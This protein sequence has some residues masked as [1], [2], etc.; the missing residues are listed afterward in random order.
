MRRN[1]LTSLIPWLFCLASCGLVL[2]QINVE[3]SFEPPTITQANNST[4]KVVINGSQQS[5]SGA[6]P[7]VDGLRFSPQPRTLKSASFINGVPSIRFELS[8]TVSPE[9][10]GSF[11]VPPWSVKVGNQSY[12][13]P[14]AKLEVLPP[15][16]QDKIKQAQKRQQQSDLRQAAFLEFSC[17]RSFLFEGETVQASVSLFL[18]ERLPVTRIEQV[19]SKNGSGFSM[20]ELGQPSEQRNVRR[21]NKTYSVYT[22][23][24][25]LTAAL[26]GLH[27]LSFDSMI[28]IRV[29]NNRNSTFSNPFF[30]DPFF[31]FGRE[32]GLTV[33]SDSTPFEI[34]ALPPA[35][36]PLNFQGAIGNLSIL[37]SIDRDRVSV[38]DPVRLTCKISGTGNL[39]AIPAPSLSLGEEFKVGP[40][41]F[42]FEGDMNTKYSGIQTFEFIITPLQAGLLEIP[43]VAFSFFQPE[44][45]KYYTLATDTHPL[46][47][48]PGEKWVAPPSPATG[49]TTQPARKSTQDLFQTESEPGEWNEKLTIS[50]PL[51][52]NTFWLSQLI[53]TGILSGVIFFRIK[54]LNPREEARRQR[55]KRLETKTREALKHKDVSG[56]HQAL[57]RRIR[58]RVGIACKHPNASALSSSEIINLLNR[59]GYPAD[60]VTGIIDLLKICDELE[61]AGGSNNVSGIEDTYEKSQA[62]LSKIK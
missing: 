29:R 49:T 56:F 52:S 5:P 31:G 27:N 6:V 54:R 42:S 18:W 30:N 22:W 59:K 10:Q 50:D 25:G 3:T 55:E 12:T 28:R 47:V 11:V 35:N 9:R 51:R 41:A 20:T 44:E 17:P 21:N 15:N 33:S 7:S 26:P 19:P 62:I 57:R 36:R 2:G 4:Y 37:S 24:F 45:E 8:F 39:A 14:A 53:L 23:N 34:R 48:D 60:L 1:I 46:R 58:L 61:Y 32:E 13:V 38:G 40:P 16:Q 43:P